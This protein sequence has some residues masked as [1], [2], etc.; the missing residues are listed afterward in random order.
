MS[1]GR[2]R[3]LRCGCG[4]QTWVLFHHAVVAAEMTLGGQVPLLQRVLVC[5]DGVVSLLQL[6]E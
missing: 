5:D 6:S 1:G 2:S 4:G 3:R